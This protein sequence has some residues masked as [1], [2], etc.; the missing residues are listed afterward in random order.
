M[1]S[2]LSSFILLEDGDYYHQCAGCL[3]LHYVP[4]GHP[5]PKATWTFHGT[6][7]HPTF[8][9]SMNMSWGKSR[10]HYTITAGQVKFHDDTTHSLRGQTVPLPEIPENVRR[11]W[12]W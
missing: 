8:K 4:V 7:E 6:P 5:K 12:G 3:Q 1:K 10:C 11:T 9:P 2:V